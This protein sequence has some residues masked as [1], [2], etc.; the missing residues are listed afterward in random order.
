MRIEEG[1]T[2]LISLKLNIVIGIV[3]NAFHVEQIDD[4]PGAHPFRKQHQVP[5]P[6]EEEMA[7]SR[8]IWVRR[9]CCPSSGWRAGK[10]ARKSDSGH[11]RRQA[12]SRFWLRRWAAGARERSQGA[13][14]QSGYKSEEALILRGMSG[15]AA[16]EVS[17]TANRELSISDIVDG[18][19]FRVGATLAY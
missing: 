11:R 1:S 13:E 6:A 4:E 5:S 16:L 3:S 7:A 14:G 8:I 19:V 10:H 12:C 2:E 18:I 9:T 17:H 15:G